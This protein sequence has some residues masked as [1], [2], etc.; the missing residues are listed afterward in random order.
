[1][2][3]YADQLSSHLRNNLASCYLVSGDEHLLV[4]ESLDEIRAAARA[5]GFASRESHVAMAGFNWSELAAA[6]ANLS[7]FSDK[8]LIELRLPTGKPGRDGSAAICDF[9]ENLNPEILL[10]VITP[11][12]D[13]SNR[14][15]K[16]VKVLTANG[17]HLPI[18]PVELRDLPGWIAQR[19]RHAGLQPDRDAVAM[20]ADRVEGNLLAA[21]QEVEKLR[22]IL[23]E[24][25]VTGDDVEKA[26]ANSTRYD[27]YKL[28]DAAVGGNAR[29]AMKILNG[30]RG[31]GIEPVI[32]VWAITRELRTLAQLA[33]NV[34]G[35]VDLGSAMQKA[36]VWKNR[37]GMVRACV[38]RHP[39]TEFYRLLKLAGRADAA[40]K[41]Q[42][43]GDP[44]Q[45]AAEI[46]V[47]LSLGGRRAA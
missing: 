1:M 38:G 30:L 33:D 37:Q 19:M 15:A 22:M 6:G 44:W 3:L 20:I 31:E 17:A 18:W 21:N 28:V 14:N 36:W 11:K 47:D 29:R 42:S 35:N 23:G 7:L 8:R 25:A 10:L 41:G 2:K 32:V 4:E 5:Q 43:P 13:K 34:R 40:A 26:V 46:L 12:L 24:G 27:V 9:V 45:L 39:H 16:W